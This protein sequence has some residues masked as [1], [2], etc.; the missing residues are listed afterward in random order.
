MSAVSDAFTALK[1]VV[2]LQE[3]LD[4]VRTDLASTA[5][6]LKTL[7]E[8]VVDIDKRLY[9]VEKIIDL[10]AAQSRQKRIEE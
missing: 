8:K 9:A 10:G 3:R 6:D 2:L 4:S 7:T 5:G 1:N